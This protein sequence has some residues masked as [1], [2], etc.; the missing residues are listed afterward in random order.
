MIKTPQ[1]AIDILVA[2][3]P[4]PIYHSLAEVPDGD[5]FKRKNHRSSYAYQGSHRKQDFIYINEGDARAWRYVMTLAHEIGHALDYHDS[6]PAQKMLRRN[7]K[8]TN[9][10][11]RNELAG[12][13]FLLAIYKVLGAK[14]ERVERR[15]LDE[16]DYLR[17][18]KRGPHAKLSEVLKAMPKAAMAALVEAHRN[19][20]AV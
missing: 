15:C 1:E 10:R 16:I 4:C 12:V 18:Y 11:Y 6:H 13:S 2:M 9:Q 20:D 5:R 19:G 8:S 7:R 17:R 14:G 3:S